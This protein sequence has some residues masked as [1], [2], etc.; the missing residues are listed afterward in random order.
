METRAAIRAKA[1]A[2]RGR[3]A[4][5]VGG[6]G[7]IGAAISVALAS[8]G[9]SLLIHGRTSRKVAELVGAIRLSGG[10]AEGL[11]LDFESPEPLIAALEAC[12]HFD[13][14]VLAF[15]PFVRKSFADHTVSD[16]EKVALLDLALPGML[17]SRYFRAMC[18]R[19]FGRILFFGGTRTDTIRGFT[20]NAAYAAAKTR[21]RRSRQIDRH[22]RSA[23]Q[24]RSR[25]RLPRYRPHRIYRTGGNRYPLADRAGRAALQS[26][27]SGGCGPRPHRPRSM[28]SIRAR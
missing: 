26:R 8:R 1:R 6:S 18:D 24:R 15:G 7:G 23:A 2:L 5:V 16:W 27:G 20:S 10:D 19:G 21:P 11:V 4:L 22:R 28:H 14:L 3:R 25:H 13:V 17:A 12:G 9:A